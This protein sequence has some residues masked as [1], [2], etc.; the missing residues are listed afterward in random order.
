MGDEQRAGSPSG[1][2]KVRTVLARDEMKTKPKA[3]GGA[4]GGL[5]ETSQTLATLQEVVNG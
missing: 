2:E 1:D 5:Y 4:S 3:S